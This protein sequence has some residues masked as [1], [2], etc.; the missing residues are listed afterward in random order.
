MSF[1]EEIGERD[2]QPGHGE[3]DNAAKGTK[4]ASQASGPPVS[5]IHAPE[6]LRLLPGWLIWRL[7]T[8]KGAGKPLKVPYWACGQRRY[9]QQ[10][11][12]HDRAQLVTF[13]AAREAAARLGFT[14][15]GLALLPDWGIAA[16]DVDHCVGP[17]GDLPPEIE[18]IVQRTYAEY[19]PSGNG[20]RAF[21]TGDLGN[22]KSSSQDGRYGLETFSS[23]GFV[24]FTGNILPHVDLLG[25]EDRVAPVPQELADLCQTRFGSTSAPD[26]DPDDFMVG[27]EP[28]LGLTLDQSSDLLQRLDPDMGRDEWIRVGLALSHEYDNSEDAFQLWH[29]WSE[30]GGKYPS[31]EALRQQWDSFERRKGARR[32]QVR[33][34]TVRMMAKEAQGAAWSAAVDESEPHPSIKATPYRCRP[35]REIPPRPWIYGYQLLGG[36]VACVIATGGSGKSTWLAGVALA[37]ASGKPLLGKS[38]W[39]GP[40]PVWVWNLEDDLDELSRSIEAARLHHGVATEDI[41]ERLYVDSGM[42]GS[43]LCTAVKDRNGIKLLE[44]VYAAITSEIRRRGIKVLIIDPFISS[45]AVEENANS[46]IDMVVKKWARV[47]KA[48]GCCVILSHH[49]NKAGA[50]EVSTHSARGASALTNAARSVLV[51]NRMTSAEAQNLGIPDA[52]RRRYVAIADDKHNRAPAEEADWFELKSLDLGNATSERPADQVGVMAKWAPPQTRQELTPEQIAEIQAIARVASHRKSRQAADWFGHAIAEVVGLNAQTL[53]EARRLERLI[54]SL[55]EKG[56][57]AVEDRTN[58][59]K[60][61]SPYIVVGSTCITSKSD[62]DAAAAATPLPDEA[63]GS[64]Q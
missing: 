27:H 47:A 51:I 54:G 22:R 29:D 59:R 5:D 15:V 7:E 34:A 40:Q 49:T 60:S 64:G 30:Q 11:G 45:H 57:L 2:G 42:D 46:E 63:T 36:T 10:G 48:T 13:A 62:N 38:V 3:Q 39:N 61:T 31:E 1:H 28:K 25:Y 55:V 44:P 23:S 32:R 26:V 37:L 19:S 50:G 20:I 35:V 12:A 9:G 24:T 6:P 33:M 8:H 52:E 14:G 58:A 53:H 17:D 18:A 43:P 56:Y 4:V 41:A 16:L 21:F